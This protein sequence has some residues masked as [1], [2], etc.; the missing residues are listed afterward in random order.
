MRKH[1][2]DIE[3]KRG[4]IRIKKHFAWLPVICGHSGDWE[5]RWL[6]YVEYEQKY[7]LF[8][9]DGAKTWDNDRFLN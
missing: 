5:Q 3:P 6:E 2:K 9:V 8:L 1:G 7:E 4:E